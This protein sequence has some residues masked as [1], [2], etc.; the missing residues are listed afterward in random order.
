MTAFFEESL[1]RSGSSAYTARSLSIFFYTELRKKRRNFNNSTRYGKQSIL[2]RFFTLQVFIATQGVGTHHK[3][4]SS[5]KLPLHQN[6]IMTHT[7][8]FIAREVELRIVFFFCATFLLRFN[9]YLFLCPRIDRWGG[10]GAYS[11]CSSDCPFVCPQK[12]L[13]WPYWMI[14][15]S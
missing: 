7:D 15:K 5:N 2:F 13:H 3:K 11:F 10:G 8:N 4:L 6:F 14:G 1:Q 9:I 12:L